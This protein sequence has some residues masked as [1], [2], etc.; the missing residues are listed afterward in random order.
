MLDRAANVFL[1]LVELGE[2]AVGIGRIDAVKR[3]GRQ[4]GA[5]PG[6]LAEQR[7]AA[8]RR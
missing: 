2:Q 6:E 1:D 8:L 5:K 4:F 3:G 7:A